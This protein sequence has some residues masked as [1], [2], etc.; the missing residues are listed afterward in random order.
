MIKKLREKYLNIHVQHEHEYEQKNDN[1]LDKYH[2]SRQLWYQ[3]RGRQLRKRGHDPIVG[4]PV[5]HVELKDFMLECW[6][7]RRKGHVI[8]Q[9]W[10]DQEKYTEYSVSAHLRRT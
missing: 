6:Q 7:H 10:A 1:P 3:W 4:F 5:W 8:Y 2:K 9:F